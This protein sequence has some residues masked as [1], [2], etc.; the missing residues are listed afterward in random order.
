MLKKTVTYTDFN[1]NKRTEEL[2]FNLTKAELVEME[3]GFE[4]G[5]KEYCAN[6]AA[7]QD[8]AQV[9][10][11]FKDIILNSYGV[12]S[13][14]GKYFIKVDEKGCRLADKF[15]QSEAYSEL[16]IQM[17][18]EPNAFAEFINGIV[19]ADMAK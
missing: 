19:P 17:A 9:M 7:A 14:D 18:Q 13:A 8:M 10:Y 3:V 6:I 4:G 15:V 1:G 11:F 2:Y 5:F 12:K 16:F